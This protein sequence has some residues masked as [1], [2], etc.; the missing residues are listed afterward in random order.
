MSLVLPSLQGRAWGMHFGKKCFNY[1][2]G[3][4]I[5]IINITNIQRDNGKCNCGGGF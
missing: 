1:Q 3:W 2:D 5:V 4:S